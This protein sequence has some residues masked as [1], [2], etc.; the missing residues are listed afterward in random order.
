MSTDHISYDEII[1]MMDADTSIPE[2]QKTL[3]IQT[4]LNGRWFSAALDEYYQN[5]DLWA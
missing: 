5:E 1:A 3:M 2:D 4:V